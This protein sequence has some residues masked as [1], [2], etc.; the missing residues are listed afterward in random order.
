[1]TINTAGTV[2]RV[3]LDNLI[4]TIPPENTDR[5]FTEQL[6]PDPYVNHTNQTIASNELDHE[7]RFGNP[8][9]AGTNRASLRVLLAGADTFTVIKGIF[10]LTITLLLEISA[11]MMPLLLFDL[12]WVVFLTV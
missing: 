11:G 5:D 3:N 12:I 6:E 2:S 9:I 10:L 7:L 8:S 4:D 1:M